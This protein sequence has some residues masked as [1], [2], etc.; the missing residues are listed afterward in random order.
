MLAE[1]VKDWTEEW[2][3]EGLEAGFKEGLK[4]G[5]KEGLKEGLKE[6]EANL[7]KRQ[8]TKRFGPLPAWALEKLDA[9]EPAQLE[10]WANG[11]FDATSL[12][13]FFRE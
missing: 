4:E 6:G 1:R 10:T 8:L 5:I 3:K 9:A 12:E 11:I 13:G 7:L 2:K